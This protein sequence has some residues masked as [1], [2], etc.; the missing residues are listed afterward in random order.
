[1]SNTLVVPCIGCFGFMIILYLCTCKS[2][3][4]YVHSST[5]I[6]PL[7]FLEKNLGNNKMFKVILCSNMGHRV[8]CVCMCSWCIWYV[9]VWVCTCVYV[10]TCAPHFLCSGLGTTLS[11]CSHLPPCLRQALFLSTVF[12]RL[13]GSRFQRVLLSLL[14]SWISGIRDTHKQKRTSYGWT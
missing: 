9:Y 14:S 3:L 10:D 12:F 11:V 1:M 2:D 13:T 5:F 7:V 4:T 8:V 6:A